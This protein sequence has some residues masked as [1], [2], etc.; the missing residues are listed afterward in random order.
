LPSARFG[1]LLK[2]AGAPLGRDLSGGALA[3]Y[4]VA[5]ASDG[6]QAEFSLVELDPAFAANDIILADMTDRKPLFENQ[7][8][9]RIVAPHDKRG[10][11]S[12]RM[13]QRLEIVRTPQVGRD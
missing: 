12:V 2:R 13:L 5:T 4:V 3:T 9:L 6:Y 1:E 7:G 11:R 8:S 10:A